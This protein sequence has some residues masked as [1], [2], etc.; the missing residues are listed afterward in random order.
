MATAATTIT[1]ENEALWAR[2][3]QLQSSTRLLHNQLTSLLPALASSIKDRLGAIRTG[4]IT[5]DWEC[6][7]ALGDNQPSAS[8]SDVEVLVI[9][10]PRRSGY[11]VVLELESSKCWLMLTPTS[12]SS[13]SSSSS[14]SKTI[15]V[16]IGDNSLS[17]IWQSFES[18]I[19]DFT[20]QHKDLL[21]ISETRARQWAQLEGD[22][23]RAMKAWFSVGSTSVEAR[24]VLRTDTDELLA[25]LRS[26]KDDGS[27][28]V[29][30]LSNAGARGLESL[31]DKAHQLVC[32]LK[33]VVKEVHGIKTPRW[34]FESVVV[35]VFEQRGWIG[36]LDEVSLASIKFI[37]SWRG[38]WR[39]IMSWE[40]I[41]SL[42][43][44]GEGGEEDLLSHMDKA[45]MSGVGEALSSMDERSLLDECLNGTRESLARLLEAHLEK[46]IVTTN[47]EESWASLHFAA[48]NG[49]QSV[50]RLLLDRGASID[51]TDK[52]GMTALHFAAQNGHESVVGLLL[53]RGASIDALNMNNQPPLQEA[54][55]S[56]HE[57][58]VGLLLDRGASIN[59][60]DKNGMTAF[61][62]AAQRGH[63]SVVGFLLDRGA[64]ID[65]T[66][67][68]GM[69]ALHKAAWNGHQP[70][71]RLLLDRGA[72]VDALTNNNQTPLH[73]AASNGHES[74]VGL[75]LDRRASIDALTNNN[76]TALH[77]AASNG[78]ES[79]VGLL[80]DRRAS[81]DALSKNNQT[82]LQ[83]AAWNGH[84]SVVGLLLDRGAFIN[85]MDSNSLSILH[86]AA[87]NGHES[88]VGLLLD[89][90][91]SIDIPDKSNTTPLHMAARQG[92]ES[93][94]GLLLDRGAS[95]DAP[96]KSNAAPLH[97]AAQ[98]GHESVVGLL[99]DRGAS[100]NAKDKNSHTSLHQAACFGHESV[101][102]LLLD[103][104]ASIDA[105]DNNTFTPLH[106]AA[107]QGHESIVRLLLDQ[108]ADTT[109]VSVRSC[110]LVVAAIVT[111]ESPSLT[112]SIQ[113]TWSIA[114][115]TAAQ[116]AKTPSLK[117]L[118]GAYSILLFAFLTRLSFVR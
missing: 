53:D 76:Q 99:L 117:R 19:K 115:G 1:D 112:P 111:T 95:I 29:K 45:S 107:R 98:S 92:H 61:H 17:K 54:A 16:P 106:M 28:V 105:I 12:P 83:K 37:E 79:V 84:E 15:R 71:V 41:S 97:M 35:E 52:D 86:C 94:V 26:C 62:F 69:I 118:I 75:L 64:S 46:A 56:G 30:R 77:M 68:N 108:G 87:H 36:D 72:S 67:K 24:A 25:L 7:V 55:W 48:L 39:R 20:E 78:H 89:R 63:D 32:A 104:G 2:A 47:S 21:N 58:V 38:C 5:I 6:E 49:Y 3:Q 4:G 22:P 109:I 113:Q 80:L 51:G 81:V 91:A 74:V 96:D 9:L 82:P 59:A 73:M 60:K 13:S 18:S 11:S 34:L 70:V 85:A 116:V 43:E 33:H 40:P 101:A 23:T 93:V 57:S 90:G 10:S 110:L 103:R 8:T 100:V 44:E 114:R 27:N 102:R 31:P 14:L 65:G 66:D 88:V 50:V 42:L